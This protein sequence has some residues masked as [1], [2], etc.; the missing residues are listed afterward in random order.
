MSV[1]P[2]LTA[3]RAQVR[4]LADRLRERF[5]TRE[6]LFLLLALVVGVVAG[7][8]S[9]L[10]HWLA[11]ALQAWW[12][13]LEQPGVRLSSLP[14][15]DWRLLLALPLFGLAVGL[16]SLIA[17][18]RKRQLVDAVEANALHGG[19][20]SMRDN[21]IVSAQTILSN[22]SGASVGLEAAYAQMGAG[23]G[24]QLGRVLR[25]RR[26][27]IRTLVG[28]GAGAAIAAAFDAPLTGAFY[29]FEIV[30]GAYSPS[31]LAPVAVA[32]LGAASVRA[33]FGGGD[34]LLPA[35]T[36]TGL[37][38][39]D[40]A[41]YAL[42]GLVC[43]LVGIGIMRLVTLIEQGVD[44]ARVPIWLRPALGGLLLV[45]LALVTPQILSSGHGALQVDLTVQ[46]PL[47]WLLLLLL[48]KSLASA[49]SLGFGFRGGLFFAS[50]FIGTLVGA[51]YAGLLGVLFGRPPLDA[52][53]AALVGMAA[54]AAGVVGAPMTMAMLVLEGTHDFAL[55]SAA[56]AAVLV[57]STVTR[58]LFGYSFSTWRL[59]LR[60]AEIRDAR[61]VGWVRTLTAGRMMRKAPDTLPAVLAVAEVR[62]R[63]P[64]G[65]TSRLV[66]VDA[67]GRYAGIA[68]LPDL[69]AD[70]VDPAAPVAQY[71]RNPATAVRE[72]D[73][74]LAVM[75]QFDASQSDELAVID[76]D[77]HVLG[78]LSERFVRKR[79]AEEL[80]RR[81]RELLGERIAD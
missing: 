59:H 13:G 76:H 63:F 31:A 34:S 77:G 38:W 80:D 50:L 9:L 5:R 54:L 60:G 42:L 33:A 26:A 67:A 40:Y 1:A 79:Y 43:A 72:E 37:E 53:T 36:S 6:H 57:S 78:L 12:Y 35:P 44:R 61:D 14:Q 64:L 66:L 55:A 68:V 29:G 74:A 70:G 7:G 10:Q 8:L 71:A 49:I 24:S 51:V 75:R 32:V 46:E 58:R 56:M 2:G 23:A 48:L 17:R 47:R 73:D 4:T 22:G 39:Q 28:T 30:I 52:T 27:D 11:H 15:V 3:A 21:L 45:P 69:Y 25:L 41:L 20:M 16:I 19:R 18:V 65:S 62:R 81:Q